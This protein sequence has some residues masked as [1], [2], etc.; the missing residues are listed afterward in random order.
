MVMRRDSSRTFGDD[1]GGT[2][3]LCL[4]FSSDLL[5]LRPV[6]ADLSV[7]V[8][9]LEAVPDLDSPVCS[10]QET[11]AVAVAMPGRSYLF[12]ER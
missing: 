10:L 1:L 6:P 7:L 2:R 5:Q 8:I 4:V 11:S 9:N 12:Q 3:Q